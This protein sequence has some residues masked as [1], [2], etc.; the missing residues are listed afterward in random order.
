VTALVV[1]VGVLVSAGVAVVL[2]VGQRDAAQQQLERRTSLVA[3]AVSSE[4][5][6]YVD[7][8][9]TIAAAA[10]AFE[11]LTS[12]TFAEATRPLA[13]RRLAG[14]TSIVFLVPVRTAEIPAVQRLWRGR[15]EPG[16]TMT[17]TGGTREHIFTVFSRPLD[18]SSP[19]VG[20]DATQS[21]AATQALNEARRAGRATV[22]D[23]YELLIDQ[24]LPASRRQLS[25][26]LTAPVY[27]PADA[28]GGRQF[29]G[30]V[31][32]GLRGREFVAATLTRV[33]QDLVDVALRAPRNDGT[34]PLVAT[35][36]ARPQGRRD[37]RHDAEISVADRR[38]LLEVRAAGRQLPGGATGLPTTILAGGTLLSVLLAGLVYVLAT[39]RARAQAR[40]DAATTELAA[41]SATAR[42]Q[43]DLLSAIMDS[44]S[45]GVAVVDNRGEFLLHN[46]AGKDILGRPDDVGGADN[47]QHHY[48]LFRPDG[49]TPFPAEDM[50]M[51]RALAGR[52]TD[53][54]EM[55]V[56]NAGHPDGVTIT[57]SGR[58]LHVAGGQLGAVAVFHDVTER[59]AA[60]AELAAAAE[61]LRAELHARVQAETDLRAFAAVAAHDLKAP[62]AAVAG[63]AEL[64]EDDLPETVDPPVRHCLDRIQ[65]GVDRMRRLID[66]LLTYATARDGVLRPE[67]VDLQELVAEVI[68]ERTAHLRNGTVPF[69]DVYTGPLPV[70]H[71]DRA[72]TRQLLDNLVGNALKHAVPGQ[73]ARIDISAR[74]EPG[75]QHVRVE[76]ADRGVGIPDAEKPHIFTTFHRIGS[77]GNRPGT[78]LGLAICH[79]IIERHQGTIG[80]ADNPGGGTR[81]SFTLPAGWFPEATPDPLPADQEVT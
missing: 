34:Y 48:G 22:S 68:A 67:P 27:G 46:P 24:Q 23:P 20:I 38:W 5:G 74:N 29:R 31:L 71:A 54:V 61:A 75:D 7:T 81:I 2:A 26:S 3:E 36:Q 45:D 21:A 12:A 8:V 42:E 63:F 18:G 55:V 57:V 70:V 35:H 17:P 72:M 28:E 25:F 53:R 37:L 16:L 33:S 30:W 1:G 6:R 14:A 52:S 10:G 69:P 80:V 58:P 50:P 59:N 78:G 60:A 32:M 15:G 44:I 65:A 43:A 62:L 77:L 40:V 56:R 76:I 39:A 73:P 64:L 66:D 51:V 9:R 19:R 11:T 79:R 47:W 41:A 4:A 13:D 49:H